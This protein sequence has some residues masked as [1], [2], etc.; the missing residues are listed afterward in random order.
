MDKKILGSMS[1]LSLEFPDSKLPHYNKGIDIYNKGFSLKKNCFL[2]NK[3][4]PLLQKGVINESQHEEGE[5]ISP[6]LL[7]QKSEDSCRM[8]LNLKSLNE[9]MPYIRMK[10]CHI[11]ILKWRSH[12]A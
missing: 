5:F 6:I 3:L 11:F 1:D 4:K 8:I 10:I 7:V 9:N 12:W 2:E